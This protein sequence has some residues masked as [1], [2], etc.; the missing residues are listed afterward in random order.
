MKVA[1]EFPLARDELMA[2]LHSENIMVRRYFWPGCHRMEPYKSLQP[3][4]GLMLPVTEDVAAK[5][6]VFP[7]G[8]G[9]GI[10]EIDQIIDVV[11]MGA[12][13]R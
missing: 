12:S 4:A 10:E 5:I 8:Y 3:N 11:Q 7:T 2:T 13:N 6:L 9:V 1:P